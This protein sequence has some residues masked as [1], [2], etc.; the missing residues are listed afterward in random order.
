MDIK[1]MIDYKVVLAI[2]AAVTSI[3]FASKL[4][5]AAAKEVSIHAIDAAKEYAVASKNACI[6]A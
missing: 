3:I 6:Q 1:V 5:L 4:D 2:G